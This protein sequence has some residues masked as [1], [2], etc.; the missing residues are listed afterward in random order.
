MNLLCIVCTVIIHLGQCLAM[1]CI[2][3]FGTSDRGA[4]VLR[5]SCFPMHWGTIMVFPSPPGQYHDVALEG[6]IPFL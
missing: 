4:A 5:F 3:R 1:I 6:G 2:Y